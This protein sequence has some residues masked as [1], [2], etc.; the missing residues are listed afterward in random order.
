MA[1]SAVAF[2]AAASVP[3]AA[4]ARA[5][6][7]TVCPP[8]QPSNWNGKPCFPQPCMP[9]FAPGIPPCFM[10]PPQIGPNGMPVIG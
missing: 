8:N 1:F 4:P 6:P 2:A 10:P 5:D 7:M 9:P 3:V